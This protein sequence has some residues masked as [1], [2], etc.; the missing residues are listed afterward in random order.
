LKLMNVR[1]ERTPARRFH[2]K[3]EFKILRSDIA[4]KSLDF[5]GI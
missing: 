5:S 4:G 3:F 1:H 2:I